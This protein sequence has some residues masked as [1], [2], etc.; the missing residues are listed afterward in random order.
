MSAGWFA[1]PIDETT[2][3]EPLARL[4]GDVSWMLD[5]LEAELAPGPVM[6]GTARV[7]PEAATVV[8][9]HR[10]VP[11]CSLVVQVAEWSS[12]VGCWWSLEED[13]RTSPASWELAAE[14]PLRP[15]GPAQAL[16]WLGRELRRPVVER[17]EGYGVARRRRWS[18]VLDDGYELPV[19][20]RW[21]PESG[22]GRW[23][24]WAA[25]ATSVL[26]WAVNATGLQL[27]DGALPRP[28]GE[29]LEV[30]ALAALLG[31]FGVAGRD[32]PARMRAGM[33]AGLLLAALG[34]A[35]G[36]VLTG[37]YEQ[38]P[39]TASVPELFGSL[40][41]AWLPTL[42]GTAALACYLVAFLG[43]P[44]AEAPRPAWPRA[45]PVA[46]GLAWGA[47]LA[48]G[49]VWLARVEPTGEITGSLAWY[50]GLTSILRSVASGLALVLLFVVLDRRRGMARRPARA[51]LAGAGLLALASSVLFQTVVGLV[52]PL[53]PLSLVLPVLGAA[54]SL[55]WLAGTAL[56]AIAAVEAPA[57]PAPA[58]PPPAPLSPRAG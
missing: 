11:G 31:W 40:L 23:L 29:A 35:A 30:L 53:L 28:T 2:L 12:S 6:L 18:V 56:L 57:T 50:G 27:G 43:L 49:L 4:V 1:D 36:L 21:S 17:A 19:R 51:G 9:P 42:L 3:G 33:L 10:L 13:P 58:A 25:V 52:S 15:D 24:L 26:G 46:A 45:L 39:P 22:E 41:G 14:F 7:D 20:V 32:R 55:T 38:P 5:R 54:F 37:P 8:L 44:A 34:Q 47:D 16:A 48:V